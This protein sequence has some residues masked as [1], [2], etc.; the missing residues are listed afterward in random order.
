[1]ASIPNNGYAAVMAG[2]N[3]YTGSNFYGSDCPKTPIVPV[4]PDDLCNKLYVDTIAGGGAVVSVNAGNNISITGTVPSPI[5]NLQRPLTASLDVGTQDIIS[6]T[7]AI[8]ITPLAGQD[9]NVNVSGAGGLH[10][11]QTSAGGTAQPIARFVNTNAATGAVTIRTNKTG[12]NAASNDVIS[13]LQFNSRNF[14]AV[15]T[16]FAKIEC[17]ATTATAG[18]TDGSIDFYTNI[19]TPNNNQLVFRL[20]GADNENNSFRPFDLNGNDLKTSTGAMTITTAASTGAGT[21]NLISKAGATAAMTGGGALQF[22]AN[23][24]AVS[25]VASSGIVSTATT[26]GINFTA[27]AGGTIQNNTTGSFA[28]SANAAI[29]LSSSTGIFAITN[30]LHYGKVSTPFTDQEYRSVYQPI[31]TATTNTFPV[32]EIQREGQQVIFINS[33]GNGANELTPVST[34]NFTITAI[35]RKVSINQTIVGG[36]NHIQG[37]AEIRCGPG[38]NDVV[39][40]ITSGAFTYIAFPVNS[41][42]YI[43]VLYNSP[44]YPDTVAVGGLFTAVAGTTYDGGANIYPSDVANFLCVDAVTATI[45]PLTMSDSFGRYGVD[46]E[47]ITI[48]AQS[49]TYYTPA[50]QPVFILGGKFNNIVGP[51]TL[52]ANRTAVFCQNGTITPTPPFDRWNSFINADNTVN[53]LWVLDDR[54][55][56]G[57][58]FNLIGGNTCPYLAFHDN[59]LPFPNTS[60]I[61]SFTPP[62]PVNTGFELSSPSTC[63]FGCLQDPSTFEYPVY[64]FDLTNMGVTPT[65]PSNIPANTLPAPATGFLSE[66]GVTLDFIVGHDV[67]TNNYCYKVQTPDFINL[68]GA[69]YLQNCFID[70]TTSPT[71]AF[72]HQ[73]SLASTVP[74]NYYLYIPITGQV[75]ITTTLALPFV[76]AL[77]PANNW[78]T[79]TLASRD[80]FATGTVVQFGTTDQRIV[81]LASSGASFSN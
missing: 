40:D 11:V 66:T 4:D 62:A 9:C 67:G 77:A 57:G 56:F 24:G 16:T 18:D 46:S 49:N 78:K 48:N 1:M 59:T 75:S 3:V 21:L 22:F 52:P 80:N 29:S 13:S 26:G 38:I 35:L 5:V 25:T 76:S 34:P 31:L 51:S 44:L 68:N 81:I 19:N 32:A 2:T 45:A 61:N 42:Y 69:T 28:V 10:T 43:N 7:S 36:F 65:I 27:N 6:T 50:S 63:Y 54:I 15:D 14:N 79:I 47:V 39:L 53:K 60:L 12:R 30:E 55:V 23:A 71:P 41:T 37:R 8:D 74:T 73:A 58:S 64:Q 70:T 20:N 72:F 33:A 17:V